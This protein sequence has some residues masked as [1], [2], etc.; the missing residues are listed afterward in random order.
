MRL[1][2]RA[3]QK[4]IMDSLDLE[5]TL[6]IVHGKLQYSQNEMKATPSNTNT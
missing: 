2:Q 3:F 4:A 5:C 6:Y 1:N